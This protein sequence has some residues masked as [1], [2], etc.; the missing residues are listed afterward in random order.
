MT[1]RRRAAPR[2]VS[3][4]PDTDPHLITRVLQAAGSDARAADELLPLVYEELRGLARARLARI[5]PGQTLQATALVHEAW[6]RV[7]GDEDPGWE[8]RAHF[9]GAAAQAMRN[10]LVEAHRRR[11]TL[12][13]GGDRER[14][15]PDELAGVAGVAIDA[16]GE[17][18]LALD[19]ALERLSAKDPLKARI[20]MLRFFTGLTM[21]AIAELTGLPLTRIERE[22]RFSR[23]W[24]QRE[25]EGT[26]PVAA[27]ERERAGDDAPGERAERGGARR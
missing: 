18:L 24:L 26:L 9:F 6:L 5:G 17:D 19:E 3:H 16:P 23:S 11:S 13:R 8:C 25:V 21:P 14:L 22:W 20:V 7:V 4:T 1:S 2:A 12:R 27:D 15:E 10:I